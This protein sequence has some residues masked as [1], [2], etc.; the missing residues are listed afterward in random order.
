MATAD[1]SPEVF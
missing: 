1:Y